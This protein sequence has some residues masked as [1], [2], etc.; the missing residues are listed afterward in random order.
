MSRVAR[1]GIGLVVLI[2]VLGL[3]GGLVAAT[4]VDGESA[5]W[6]VFGIA[7]AWVALMVWWALSAPPARSQEASARYWVALRHARFDQQHHSGDRA[8]Q[9]GR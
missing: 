4:D 7:F 6:I 9:H 2:P 5:A 1:L 8:G 3:V